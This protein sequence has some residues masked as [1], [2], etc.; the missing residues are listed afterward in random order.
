MGLYNSEHGCSNGIRQLDRNIQKLL[1]VHVAK[2]EN[3]FVPVRVLD[4]NSF[5]SI[6]IGAPKNNTFQKYLSKYTKFTHYFIGNLSNLIC[7]GNY[8]Y[9]AQGHLES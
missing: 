5:A 9:S 4:T 1:Y 2:N 6:S 8:L 7:H 3:D